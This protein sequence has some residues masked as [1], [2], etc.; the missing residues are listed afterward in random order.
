MR[1]TVCK[2]VGAVM[3]FDSCVQLRVELL[4]CEECDLAVFTGS[5]SIDTEAE[6]LGRR[7]S[8]G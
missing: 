7:S 2:A 1:R 8:L 3:S 5:W 4:R 6:R